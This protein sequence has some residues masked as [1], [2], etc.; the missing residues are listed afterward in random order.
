MAMRVDRRSAA[1]PQMEELVGQTVRRVWV[2]DTEIILDFE[3]GLTVQIEA[4]ED[5]LRVYCGEES[6]E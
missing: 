5:E 4:D 1:G 3:G 2:S 6:T